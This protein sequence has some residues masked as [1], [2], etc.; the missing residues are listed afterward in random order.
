MKE[1]LK[2]KFFNKKFL[3]E[4]LM[5]NLGVFLSAFAF[6]F[7]LDPHNIVC[8]GVGGI[9]TI[10]NNTIFK[11][12]QTSIIVFVL[13]VVLLFISLIFLGKEFF[14]KTVY[15]SVIFPV[16]VF[17][18]EAIYTLVN[19]NNISFGN[20]KI[21]IVLASAA[22]MG[23]GLGLAIKN[24]A[25]TGGVDIPQYI[26]LKYFKIPLSVSLFLIDGSI[27]LIGAIV[28]KDLSNLLY[29]T[30]FILISGYILDNVVFG[31][32]NVRSVNIV[33]KKN[34]EIKEQII[35][36]LDRTV[37]EIDS[38]GGY[39]NISSKM[40][41][42]VLSTKEYYSLRS[43]INEIDPEAF[44]FVTKASEVRGAG[45]TYDKQYK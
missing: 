27:V 38:T 14:L 19:S 3:K 31:G 33:S 21:L 10:L 30:L 35:K 32:F 22:I 39:S 44:V 42:C 11:N 8:G 9:G 25:S 12:I 41:I 20:E 16:Y 6:S 1:T 7:F 4:F 34:H 26:L 5:I 29:G 2:E 24:G 17:I 36:I 28:A 43:I 40:L 23:L 15:G 18:C 37:T 13:N 45:F